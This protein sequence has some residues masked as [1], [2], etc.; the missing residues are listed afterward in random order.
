MVNFKKNTIG[1]TKKRVMLPFLACYNPEYNCSM[2]DQ[3]NAFGAKNSLSADQILAIKE[4]FDFDAFVLTI[5]NHY[6]DFLNEK[7]SDIFGINN[8]LSE[9]KI[10][11][12]HPLRNV[13]K[14]SAVIDTA[15]ILAIEDLQSKSSE[16]NFN[17]FRINLEQRLSNKL[18]VSYD[19]LPQ[20]PIDT[21]GLLDKPYKLWE[22]IQIECLLDVL[23]QSLRIASCGRGSI[24]DMVDDIT[25]FES[26]N[27]TNHLNDHKFLCIPESQLTT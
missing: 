9:V 22:N 11:K 27:F 26:I 17:S 6:I 10:H 15:E 21:A 5:A 12:S 2:V 14:V 24:V 16:H 1:D 18:A 7:L 23:V 25:D 4:N 13:D 19:F 8:A 3:V 20:T